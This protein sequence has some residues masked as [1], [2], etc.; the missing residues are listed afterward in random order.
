MSGDFWKQDDKFNLSILLYDNKNK[1]IVWSDSWIES[2]E[3]LGL[4]KSK[5]VANILKILSNEDIEESYESNTYNI[6]SKAY[7]L[8]LKAKIYLKQNT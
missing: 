7:Q 1:N 2:W 8:Y 4:I 3:N 6:N 5:L